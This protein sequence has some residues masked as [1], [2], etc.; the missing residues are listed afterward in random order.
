MSVVSV[1]S[2]G[3]RRRGLGEDRL[4]ALKDAHRLLWRSGLPK[5][6]A[7][8]ILE[9]RFPASEDVRALI[10]FLRAIDRGKNGRA[11]ESLRGAGFPDPEEDAEK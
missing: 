5:P 1:N 4:H 3:L 7:I 11:R 2:V 9:Q 6:E 8:A 10:E